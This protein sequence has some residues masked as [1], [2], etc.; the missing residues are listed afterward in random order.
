MEAT[1]KHLKDLK[2]KR[3]LAIKESDRIWNELCSFASELSLKGGSNGEAW[4][5]RDENGL[6]AVFRTSFDYETNE[7]HICFG[8]GGGATDTR[9]PVNLELGSRI[10]K[11][12]KDYERQTHVVKIMSREYEEAFRKAVEG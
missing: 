5:D 11:L 12:T 2:A 1:I 10:Y 4:A 7:W 6:W 8:V 3:D 9:T